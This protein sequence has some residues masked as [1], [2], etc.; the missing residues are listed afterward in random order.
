MGVVGGTKS[1]AL[2]NIRKGVWQG[3]IMSVRLFGIHCKCH[4][5][6]AATR[7]EFKWGKTDDVV[8]GV[9]LMFLL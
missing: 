8:S 7:L 4:C 9:P 6:L 3:C 5:A 1:T 2:F